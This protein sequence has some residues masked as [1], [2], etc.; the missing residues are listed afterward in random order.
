MKI[1]QSI[2]NWLLKNYRIIEMII[3]IIFL[4]AFIFKV[5]FLIG[6]S[7]TTLAILYFIRSQFQM[8]GDP[9]MIKQVIHFGMP[10]AWAISI[11]GI[12]FTILKLPGSSAQIK[13]GISSM[14][15]III[16]HLIFNF[17]KNENIIDERLIRSLI[18]LLSTILIFLYI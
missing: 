9:S 8:P 17:M 11:I 16:I 3:L 4:I 1:P 2:E 12:M 13:V 5:N 7:L 6:I 18:L 14:S 15:V 10:I